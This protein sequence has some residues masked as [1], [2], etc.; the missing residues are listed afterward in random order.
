MYSRII[1]TSA[2]QILSILT[3][4]YI[5]PLININMLKHS[6][7]NNVSGLTN[8]IIMLHENVLAFAL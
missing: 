7:H 6:K 3:V 8:F 5:I 4:F 1:C 2:E